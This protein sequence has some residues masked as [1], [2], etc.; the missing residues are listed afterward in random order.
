[1]QGVLSAEL[2][3]Q[4]NNGRQLLGELRDALSRF[5]ASSEDQAALA[6]SI[7]QLDEFFLLVVVGEF[8][9]GKSAFINALVGQRVLQEGVTTTTARIHGLRYGETVAQESDEH[10]VSVTTAP[11]EL[12]REVHIV[13]TPGTNAII[14]E[15]EQLTTDFVPR[16][17]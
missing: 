8:N 11:A 4:L 9:A 2:Q 5:G 16:A 6:S 14:R 12:L 13:D 7:R 1:M 17:D 3:T 15:H 10:G